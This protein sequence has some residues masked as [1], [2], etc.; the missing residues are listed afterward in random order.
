MSEVPPR[1]DSINTV[2]DT[3]TPEIRE[4]RLE[5][6]VTLEREMHVLYG[7]P[8]EQ[9]VL[10]TR[11]R[12]FD[13]I[14]NVKGDSP[15]ALRQNNVRVGEIKYPSAEISATELYPRFCSLMDEIMG[16]IG[17]QTLPN[18]ELV[19]LRFAGVMYSMGIMIHPFRDGNGQT[20]RIMATSY[21][22]EISSSFKDSFLPARREDQ[23]SIPLEFSLQSIAEL[24]EVFDHPLK[25]IIF[26]LNALT[27]KAPTIDDS[28]GSVEVTRWQQ[29]IKGVPAD[30]PITDYSNHRL[31]IQEVGAHYA[32]YRQLAESEG[33]DLSTVDAA[34]SVR[35][36][37]LIENYLLKLLKEEQSTHAIKD[38]VLGKGDLEDEDPNLDLASLV[39]KEVSH[40][41][42]LSLQTY[43]KM[44]M[45]QESIL[46]RV[47][48][49]IVKR[50]FR[51]KK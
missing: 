10:E 22:H 5:N 9:R 20:F 19:A 18:P 37:G 40:Q 15:L 43:E 29:W 33:V 4:T 49:D 14:A 42:A 44:N 7:L 35:M 11:R 3:D 34:D 8:T 30:L 38:Y 2:V 48:P 50:W 51:S 12:I 23:S 27:S 1:I 28:S 25:N 26:R 21:L 13:G 31:T 46:D 24:D 36:T 16:E 17:A 32:R 6:Q 45:P 47:L 41:I 39:F